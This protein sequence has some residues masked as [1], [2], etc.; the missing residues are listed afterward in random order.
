MV[1]KQQNKWFFMKFTKFLANSIISWNWPSKW[2]VLNSSFWKSS[3]IHTVK[4]LKTATPWWM[5]KW[6]SY[7][8]GRLMEVIDVRILR[9]SLH[10]GNE[11]VAV[12]LR[13]ASYRCPS[14][15]FTVCAT[16][17]LKL[18]FQNYQNFKFFKK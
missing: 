9:V 1:E 8:G 11:T 13:W 7:R 4:P 17:F 6:P 10:S 18:A 15:G 2:K 3:K 12:S 14:W 5:K 16:V